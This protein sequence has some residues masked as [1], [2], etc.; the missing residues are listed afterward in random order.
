V[1]ARNFTV[2]PG[3]QYETEGADAVVR[4]LEDKLSETLSIKDFGAIGDDFTDNYSFLVAA[5][6]A[7]VTQKKIL[8]VPE[9]RYRIKQRGSEINVIN[10]LIIKGTGGTLVWDFTEGAA[11]GGLIR[12]SGSSTELTLD[13]IFFDVVANNQSFNSWFGVYSD[14]KSLIIQNCTFNKTSGTSVKLVQTGN[15]DIESIRITDCYF[16]YTDGPWRANDSTG[17]TSAVTITNNT[18]EFSSV[19]GMNSPSGVLNNVLISIIK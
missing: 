5:I 17:T 18:F 19:I 9:G 1:T 2:V 3:F 7:A 11:G 6:N 10:S 12:P 15:G 8:T 16:K 13:N 4:T 14:I